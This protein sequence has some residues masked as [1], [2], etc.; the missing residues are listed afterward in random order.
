MITKTDSRCGSYSTLCR[1][2]RAATA[3]PTASGV[4]FGALLNTC[5]AY[6]ALCNMAGRTTHWNE[7]TS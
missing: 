3:L 4:A 7:R 5:R 2:T 6:S 1:S